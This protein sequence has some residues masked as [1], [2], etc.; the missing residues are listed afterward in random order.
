MKQ[1]RSRSVSLKM[2]VGDGRKGSRRVVV[3]AIER[4]VSLEGRR[5]GIAFRR[6]KRWM[7]RRISR[8]QIGRDRLKVVR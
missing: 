6:V 4:W 2:V 8:M 1:I 5:S 7:R 3:L